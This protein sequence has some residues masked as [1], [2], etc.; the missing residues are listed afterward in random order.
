MT[1][2]TTVASSRGTCFQ[3]AQHKLLQQC[4]HGWL[5][6]ARAGGT[7]PW[8]ALDAAR[9]RQQPKPRCSLHWE[10]PGPSRGRGRHGEWGGSHPRAQQG[11]FLDVRPDQGVSAH[12][13]VEEGAPILIPFAV[14]LGW[15]VQGCCCCFYT[16]KLPGLGLAQKPGPQEKPLIG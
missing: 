13:L 9:P 1:C 10:V 16:G 7:E 11:G 3:Q 5:T 6:D 12:A 15:D 14:G 4:H 8:A 2:Q